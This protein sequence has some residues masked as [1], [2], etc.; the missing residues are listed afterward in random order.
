MDKKVKILISIIIILVISVI[1]IFVINSNES[2]KKSQGIN[3]VEESQMKVKPEGEP[4]KEF[5]QNLLNKN[6]NSMKEK[7]EY[8]KNKI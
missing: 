5:V 3:N 8:I 2:N 7:D 6:Q 1:V 4:N